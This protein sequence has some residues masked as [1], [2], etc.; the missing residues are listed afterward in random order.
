MKR[1][2]IFT[3]AACNYV[4]K[5]RLL[6]ESVRKFHP[7]AVLH[8]LLADEL[9]PGLDL[10][11]ETLDVVTQAKDLGIPDFQGWAFC[12]SIVELATAIKPF[13]L[14]Q[15]LAS[16]DADQV[17]YLDPDTVLFSRLDDVCE[18]LSSCNLVLTPHQTEPEDCIQGILDNELCSL[19]HGAYNLGFIAVAATDEGR[20]FAQYWAERCYFFCRS[21]VYNGLFTDQKWIDLVPGM[22]D[23]VCISRSPRHNVAPWNLSQREISL[24]SHGQHW[25]NGEPLGFYHFTGFDSGAHRIASAKVVAK[26]PA[27]SGL[28]AW[29]SDRIAVAATDP[30]SKTPWRYAAFPNGAPIA[31][32]QRLIYRQRVD[33]QRDFPNPFDTGCGTELALWFSTQGL[34]EHPLLFDEQA[35]DRTM[36]EMSAQ[37]G[38]V[39]DP[40]QRSPRESFAQQLWHAALASPRSGL[41]LVRRGLSVLRAEGVA[42]VRKRLGGRPLI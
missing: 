33:L 15:L 4:P 38:L 42:G 11:G 3:S 1:L 10:S 21:E 12:H 23:G 6:F 17:I 22:F 26:N 9:P 37:I 40:H 5:V 13:Y 7:E 31:V 32:A 25:V 18:A 8:L 29:Y 30:L 34:Q 20:R 36:R 14:R 35:L 19:R 39:F 41:S 27:V 28:I 16:G 2:H 24:D